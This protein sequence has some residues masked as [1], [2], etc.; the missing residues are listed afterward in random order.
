M[1][2]AKASNKY[3]EVMIEN[4]ILYFQ[5]KPLE[6]LSLSI[7]KECL[8]LRLSVQKHWAYPILCDLRK[9]VQADKQAMDYLAKEGSLQT[10]AVA[11]LVSYPHTFVTAGFYITTSK[12]PTPTQ[13]FQD[14][15]S[16]KVFLSNYPKKMS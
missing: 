7:A 15:N 5:Y 6:N 9:V 13:T 11:L 1:I 8:K 10:T 4:N 2:S 14:V 12:P 16:A 3:A